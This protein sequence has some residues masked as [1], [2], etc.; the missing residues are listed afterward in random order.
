MHNYSNIE[1]IITANKIHDYSELFLRAASPCGMLYL[2]SV[3]KIITMFPG[4]KN[5]NI[6]L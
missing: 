6:R 3:I 5:E 2:I 1:Y 4:G